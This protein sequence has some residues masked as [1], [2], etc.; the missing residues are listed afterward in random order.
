[1]RN[2]FYNQKFILE[3]VSPIHIGSGMTLQ[4]FE[5]LYVPAERKMY[6][7]DKEK[8]LNL[9]VEYGLLDKFMQFLSSDTDRIKKPDDAK[10]INVMEWLIKNKVPYDEIIQAMGRK[11]A[12]SNDYDRAT[13]NTVSLGIS[14]IDDKLYI[15]GSSIKGVFRTAILYALLSKKENIELKQRMSR[16]L[17]YAMQEEG[18]KRKSKL[19]RITSTFEAELLR[20]LNL[21]ENKGTRSAGNDILRGL[22]VSDALP[23]EDYESV[24]VEKLDATTYI[25]KTREVEKPLP[26]FRECIKPKSKFAFSV[27]IDKDML[28]KIGVASPET[29]IKCAHSFMIKGLKLQAKVFRNEYGTQFQEAAGAN[30]FLGA[31]T[32]FLQKS[33]WFTLCDDENKGM[34]MLKEFLDDNFR[35]HRHKLLDKKIS[36]RTLK[37][38]V[39]E[40]HKQMMG[41]CSIKEV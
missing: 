6:L 8:W 21:D 3:A 33:L 31:G 34:A 4:P 23:V 26:V 30:F 24:L 12:V 27:T 18:N 5:Y 22:K 1:M 13:L 41:L 38:A 39:T 36:P 2:F 20:N 14:G 40:Q 19:K 7:P 35:K 10:K 29:I 17:N 11:I 28:Q 25:G 37:L 15:P 32:G 16:E 9:L